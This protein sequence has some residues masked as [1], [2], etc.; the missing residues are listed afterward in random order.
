MPQWWDMFP[1][2]SPRSSWTSLGQASR[3]EA[4]SV[5]GG[6]GVRRA[7][8]VGDVEAGAAWTVS[9]LGL[10]LESLIVTSVEL[11][12]D[13]EPDEGLEFAVALRCR[14]P[15]NLRSASLWRP[16]QGRL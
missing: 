16:W 1:A 15:R 8:V 2:W 7:V 12:P 3:V 4:V 14:R 11:W 6:G 10:N 9:V 13:D 5:I